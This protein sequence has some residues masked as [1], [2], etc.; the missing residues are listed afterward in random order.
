M[1]AQKNNHL[2]YN[3]ENN[4][5]LLINQLPY[6]LKWR[7]FIVGSLFHIPFLIIALFSGQF[8]NALLSGMH[9]VQISFSICIMV[10][11]YYWETSR[12]EL[13]ELIIGLEDIIN[14]ARKYEK[15]M[16]NVV[17]RFTSLKSFWFS[18]PL[19][20]IS[21]SYFYFGIYPRLPDNFFFIPALFHYLA[22][23]FSIFMLYLL[24]SIGFWYLYNVA[25]LYKEISQKSTIP[26]FILLKSPFKKFS[27]FPFNIS[28][29]L[30]IIEVTVLP[31][32]IY[33]I[34]FYSTK[35]GEYYIILEIF[36][37]FLAVSFVIYLF[38]IMNKSIQKSI[39][40]SK[41]ERLAE[42][43]SQLEEC[44]KKIHMIIKSEKK[45]NETNNLDKLLSYHAYLDRIRIEIMDIPEKNTKFQMIFE[46]FVLILPLFTIILSIWIEYISKSF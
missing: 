13:I 33:L 16:D 22:L 44:E 28:K 21:S 29:Y 3:F 20:I 1:T 30:L 17:L 41:E 32:L 19:M 40:K 34:Y 38:C 9:L 39:L 15:L 7:A 4:L 37:I 10:S 26:F 43:I 31:I 2:E 14:D 46:M 24:G 45:V 12:L 6:S 25:Q 42:V 23:L 36:G 18:I 35:I 5:L 8:W 11:I 27:D